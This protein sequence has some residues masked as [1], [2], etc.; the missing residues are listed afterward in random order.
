MKTS[1]QLLLC[2]LALPTTVYADDLVPCPQDSVNNASAI[3]SPVII[4][5][6]PHTGTDNRYDSPYPPFKRTPPTGIQIEQYGH[7]LVIPTMGVDC[8]VELLDAD[9][10]ASVYQVMLPADCPDCPVPSELQGVFTLQ[11]T[12]DDRIYQGEILL[13]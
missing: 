2:L 8:S 13:P 12:M 4:T 3:S 11:L 9:T 6:Y 10:D 1:R 5:L 7:L